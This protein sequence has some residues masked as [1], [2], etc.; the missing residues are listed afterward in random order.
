MTSLISIHFGNL[1][2][3]EV[4]GSVARLFRNC[5]SLKYLD[6]SKLDI[7]RILY[8]DDIFKG[9]SSLEY[10]NFNNYVES[11]V[12]LKPSIGNEIPSNLVICLNQTNAP[13]LYNTLSNRKC[14]VIYCREDWR[15]HQTKFNEKNECVTRCENDYSYEYENICYK[16]CPNGTKAINFICEKEEI[17]L[18]E[19][20]ENKKT[21][22]IEI[23]FTE[24]TEM[25]LIKKTEFILTD[26][27]EIIINNP[28]NISSIIDIN[29]INVLNEEIKAK[30][31]EINKF[32]KDIENGLLDKII[33]NISETKDGFIQQSDDMVFQISTS[34]NQ[35]NN[36]N[37]NISSLELGNCENILKG[38]YKID[39]SEPLII[40]KIDYY[41]EGLLIPI[42]GYEIYH[43]LNKSKLDL[44]YCEEEFIKLNIP[45]SID[46]NHLFKYDPN[47]GYYKDS[48]FSFTT[49]KGTNIILSDRKEEFTN[50]N[51]SLCENKCNYT[52]YD[53]EMKQSSCNCNIKNK[54]DLISEIV[55]N[56]DKLSNNIDSNSNSQSTI[57]TMKCTKVLFTKDGLIKKNIYFLSLTSNIKNIF[58]IF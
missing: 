35:K 49:E 7:S 48:C 51:F 36:K 53:K 57:I 13:S 34:E 23:K 4:S 3:S 19:M 10:I 1:D 45:V 37:K 40:F 16:I 52:G 42:V 33:M 2:T 44:T 39:E 22:E 18:T 55:D 50:N 14:T 58:F 54:M 32:R 11:K 56:P 25:I 5:Y 30:D 24:K 8:L 15:E 28:T 46:E 6:L 9:C 29:T 41:S 26:K 17:R 20:V 27:E 47:S 43:P 38:V 12:S 31:D 21:E